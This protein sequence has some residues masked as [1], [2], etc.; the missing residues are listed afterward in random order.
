[1]RASWNWLRSLLPA[2]DVSAKDAADRLTM[3]G[4]EVEAITP[5]GRELGPIVVAEVQGVEPHPSRSGLR[6]VRVGPGGEAASQTVVCGAPNVPGPGGLV[7]LAPL[8]T[9]LPA[10]GLTVGSRAIGGVVSEGMLCSESE[11]GVG[12]EADGILVLPAGAARAG[13]KLAAWAPD[14]VDEVFDIGVTPNRAD[15]LGHLGLARELAALYG[16]EVRPPAFERPAAA[17]RAP[18][19]V[20]V[21]SP[22]RCL[23]L[24]AA[25]VDGVRVG[26]SPLW[27]RARLA[28]L[29]VRPIN[30]V[31]DVTNLL[32]LLY[33]QPSHAYDLARLRGGRLEARRARAGERLTTLDSAER[34]LDADD[35]VIADGAGPVGLAGVMGGESSE[36]RPDTTRVALECANFEPRGVRRTTRRHGLHTEGSHRFERGVDRTTA[37]LALEHGVALLA[38]LAGGRLEGGVA[39]VSAP[40]PAR[41]AIRLRSGRLDALLGVSVPW[42]EA[43]DVL[44]RLGCRVEAAGEAEARVT[45]PSWRAD[46]GREEDLIEEVARVRGLDA[47]PGVLPPIWPQPPRAEGKL[48]AKVRQRA[49]E[50]GLSEA[51]TYGFVSRR[52]LEALGAPAPSVVLSKPLQEERSVMRTSLLPGLLEAVGRA[53]RRG[54]RSARLF[55]VGTRFLPPRAGSPLPTEERGFAAALAGPRASYLE[56]AVEHDVYDA[57]AVALELVERVSG[58]EARAEAYA[59]AERPSRLHPRAAGRVLVGGRAVG[60]FGL[61]HPSVVDALELGGALAVVELDLGALGELGERVPSAR[62]VPRLPPVTRDVSVYV[63]D[64]VPAGEVEA[65]VREAAGELCAGVEIF[66]LFRGPGVPEGHHSLTFHVVYRDPAAAAGRPEG[67]TLTDAEVDERHRAV[68][69]AVR[70]RFGATLRS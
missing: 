30:N 47:I 20:A 43:R 67:R 28:R 5:Y 54:E 62:P 59:A 46:L 21:E 56:K 13:E 16:L 15:A 29:G 22:E 19:E 51:L 55:C 70:A 61:L 36:I 38:E 41:P 64:G 18:I 10:K 60:S 11:L 48:E 63:R 50:L 33:G 37:P 35:L 32:T 39:A 25:V 7:A 42:A 1:M 66:D 27:L 53:R 44:E 14:L 6:L 9:H 17:G 26:P 49:L 45:P 12:D 24:G 58:H 69:E 52:E 4:L 40:E 31:V 68:N 3:A 2:L 8:G 34:A 23:Y 65:A 57:K